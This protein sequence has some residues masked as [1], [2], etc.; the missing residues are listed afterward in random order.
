[1]GAARKLHSTLQELEQIAGQG[2]VGGFFDCPKN[3][4]TLNALADDIHNAMMDYQVCVS[5]C[6]ALLCLTSPLDFI[7]A[8]Y[9]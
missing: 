8:R 2:M 1:M 9:L 7:R 5:N 4:N 6:S 3:A